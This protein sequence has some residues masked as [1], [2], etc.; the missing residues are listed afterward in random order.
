MSV[1][2]ISRE[3]AVYIAKHECNN[4]KI[5]IMLEKLLP[6]NPKSGKWKKT[7]NRY[8]YWYECSACGCKVPKNEWGAEYFSPFCP[9]CGAAMEV[10]E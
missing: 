9:E 10:D 4:L 6:I 3:A 2:C 7:T 1:D 5:A 8:S